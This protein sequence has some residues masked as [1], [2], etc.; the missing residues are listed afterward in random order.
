MKLLEA[1]GWT[2]EGR[3]THG[4]FY[5]KHFPGERRPRSTVVPDKSSALPRSTLGAILSAKQTGL[6]S[7][8]LR[9]LM[10]S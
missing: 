7:K 8:W 10:N 5:H 2:R 9:D 6:G 3:W 1:D 4:V